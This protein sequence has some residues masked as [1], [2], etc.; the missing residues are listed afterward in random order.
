MKGKQGK[1]YNVLFCGS[2]V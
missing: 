1:G 2:E